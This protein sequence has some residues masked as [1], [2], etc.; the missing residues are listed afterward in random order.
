MSEKRS[1]QIARRIP[2]A[3]GC[4]FLAGF[5][6]VSGMFSYKSP[7]SL[8]PVSKTLT[9]HETS[10]QQVSDMPLTSL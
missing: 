1:P 4:Y 8:Y 9:S 3:K 10:L 5:L 2:G 6:Q 7:R